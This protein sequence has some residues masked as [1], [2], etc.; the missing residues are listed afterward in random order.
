MERVQTDSIL[1][2]VANAVSLPHTS[3]TSLAASANASLHGSATLSHSHGLARSGSPHPHFASDASRPQSGNANVGN[4]LSRRGHADAQPQ[5]PHAGLRSVNSSSLHLS[6]NNGGGGTLNKSGSTKV[7]A[8]SFAKGFHL[9][10]TRARA[11]NSTVDLTKFSTVLSQ[12]LDASLNRSTA[13]EFHQATADFHAATAPRPL[14]PQSGRPVPTRPGSTSAAP[15]SPTRTGGAHLPA[16]LDPLRWQGGPFRPATTGSSHSSLAPTPQSRSVERIAA[17]PPARAEIAGGAKRTLRG[18]KLASL[19]TLVVSDAEPP[20]PPSQQTS[21]TSLGPSFLIQSALGDARFPQY[22]L[23]KPLGSGSGPMPPASVNA[24]GQGGSQSLLSVA[25]G[26]SSSDSSAN[27]TSRRESKAI[28]FTADVADPPPLPNLFPTARTATT[29]TTVAVPAFPGFLANGGAPGFGALDQVAQLLPHP[30]PRCFELFFHSA[31]CDEFLAD[32]VRYIQLYMR[33][34]HAQLAA[35][36][37]VGIDQ[38]KRLYM[39]QIHA[40]SESTATTDD[41]K[42][43][44]HSGRASMAGAGATSPTSAADDASSTQ[45]SASCDTPAPPPA[46]ASTTVPATPTSPSQPAPSSP[47]R[48][49]TSAPTTSPAPDSLDSLRSQR[50][51]AMHDLCLRY[52]RILRRYGASMNFAVE[53]SFYECFY[54]M[55]GEYFRAHTTA[56]EWNAVSKHLEQIFQAHLV[57]PSAVGVPGSAG[58]A[59]AVGAVAN[60]MGSATGSR[61]STTFTTSGAAAS[62]ATATAAARSAGGI[63]TSNNVLSLGSTGDTAW[64]TTTATGAGGGANSFQQRVTRAMSHAVAGTH[65]AAAAGAPAGGHAHFDLFNGNDSSSGPASRRMSMATDGAGHRLLRSA[66]MHVMAGLPAAGAGAGAAAG[67]AEPVAPAARLMSVVNTAMAMPLVVAAGG[68]AATATTPATATAG[69]G[70]KK[71]RAPPQHEVMDVIERALERKKVEDARQREREER[72]KHER[73]MN[74]RENFSLRSI[75]YARSPLIA[76]LMPT[77]RD[78]TVKVLE[79][80]RAIMEGNTKVYDFLRE[81]TEK[82]RRTHAPADW[83]HPSPELGPT[84]SEPESAPSMYHRSPAA[85]TTT[86]SAA[87]SNRGKPPRSPS[88]HPRYP[89]R[90]ASPATSTAPTTRTR[91]NSNGGLTASPTAPGSAGAG[92]GSVDPRVVILDASDALCGGAEPGSTMT[93]SLGTPGSP[94]SASSTLLGGGPAALPIAASRLYSRTNSHAVSTSTSA[95]LMSGAG[96]TGALRLA[97]RTDQDARQL[98][99]LS[100]GDLV[101]PVREVSEAAL[102]EQV[103]AAGR[104][105]GGGRGEVVEEEEDDDEDR[106]QAAGVPI[107]IIVT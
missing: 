67:A 60:P 66:A 91:A 39:A 48:S 1:A 64:P 10:Q 95:P 56:A 38:L 24:A 49:P 36:S 4:G 23:G 68:T 83:Q 84:A 65:A 34:K 15:S 74:A 94:P 22:T 8:A 43:A 21:P 85:A 99:E 45:P 28:T 17:A 54:M 32:G 29:T 58:P 93:A 75:I 50:D 20:P 106:E 19:V 96:R 97:V 98:A 37:K 52:C 90:A 76:Q 73:S 81:R 87:A 42:P 63:R 102:V 78:Q 70:G 7:T 107:P 89:P 25:A 33:H 86:T 51:A 71:P 77:A 11:A 105:G 53:R 44:K 59:A 100:L 16:D 41:A 92:A 3:T 27:S 57:A 30:I 88:Y 18:P 82:S 104:V 61:R 26:S 14:G 80:S 13:A 62:S 5:H 46:A 35:E 47:S 72:R 31:E 55:L 2:L 40:Q 101:E 103:M 69:P 9:P 12:E 79:K 6:G